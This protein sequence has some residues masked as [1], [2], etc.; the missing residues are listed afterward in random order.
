MIRL[1]NGL[2]LYHASYTEIP[3]IDLDKCSS[4]LDFGKGFYLTSSFE[5]AYGYVPGSVRKAIRLGRVQSDFQ[6]ADGVINIYKY[7]ADPSLLIH[8]FEEADLD[9]LHFI[10]SN[11]DRTLFPRLLEKYVSTDI[12]GGKVA[13]DNTA[14]TINAYLDGVLGTPGTTEA[15]D[16]TIRALLPN[17]LQDQF[18]FRTMDSVAALEYVRSERY[19]DTHISK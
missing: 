13:N 16:F 18:C 3:I 11:R 19:G 6:M 10:A 9:W 7:H 2:T 14:R 15:D 12:V 5:Q 17:R 1:T 4:G 8:Y